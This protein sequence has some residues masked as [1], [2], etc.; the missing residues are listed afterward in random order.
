[1][2]MS[3]RHEMTVASASIG[4]LG[5]KNIVAVADEMAIVAIMG[6]GDETGGKQVCGQGFL[7]EDIAGM[8][9]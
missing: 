1:M 4:W 2:V 8:W 5:L 3:R 7:R 9:I 6:I